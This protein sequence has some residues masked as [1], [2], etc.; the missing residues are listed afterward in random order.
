MSGLTGI[1]YKKEGVWQV[2]ENTVVRCSKLW[3]GDFNI[4]IAFERTKRC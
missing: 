3:C 2:I 1:S 4:K